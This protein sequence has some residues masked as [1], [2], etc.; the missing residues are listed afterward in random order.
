MLFMIIEHFRGGDP[1][2]VDRRFRDRGR[3]ASDGL[4]DVA[5]WVATDLERCFQVM[6]CADRALLDAWMARW[7]DLVR[8]EVVPVL[9]SH[10]AVTAVAPRL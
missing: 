8:F 4:T 7:E 2:P 9:S 1:V 3:L 6:E 10:E 5:N